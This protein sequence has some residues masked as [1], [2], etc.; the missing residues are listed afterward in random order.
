MMPPIDHSSG[1]THCK[2]LNGLEKKEIERPDAEPAKNH[3]GSAP[4]RFFEALVARQSSLLN[5]LRI[6]V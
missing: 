5:L 2:G 3:A 4:L 6:S 1:D